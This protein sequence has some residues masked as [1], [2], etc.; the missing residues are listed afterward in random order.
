[1]IKKF[2]AIKT[3]SNITKDLDIDCQICFDKTV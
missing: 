3:Y 1:M 2:S